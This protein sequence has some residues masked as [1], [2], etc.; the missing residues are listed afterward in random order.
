VTEPLRIDLDR[1]SPV[2][3]Y[4]QVSSAFA[5]AIA[6]GRLVPGQLLENEIALAARLGISRPTARQALQGLVERGRLVRRR[7]VG[8]QVAPARFHRPVGLTSLNDDLVKS[9]RT[10]GT[11]VLEHVQITAGAD[12][13]AGLEIEEG[14]V[15]VMIRRLRTAD[16]EPL[17]VLTN[18]IPVAVAPTA[19]EL[20]T[21]GLYDALRSRGV[22]P[23]LARQRIG[24]RLATA[25][26]ARILGEP[27]R[28]ALLTMERTA[29]DEAG[30]VIEYARHI[31]PASRHS[32]DTTVF[33]N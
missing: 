13:A 31:Y 20:A 33:S 15:V 10:P 16:G 24:A 32:F 19:E 5:A 21:T 2:P 30:G 4:H 11:Q 7:G 17:A 12:V 22:R 14:T 18:Y 9:G 27:R 1:S 26:E 6:D 25:A 8:T 28:S 3:L 23:R 29:Y